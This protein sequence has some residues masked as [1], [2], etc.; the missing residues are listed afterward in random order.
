MDFD[1]SPF[2]RYGL[3]GLV[4]SWFIWRD[5]RQSSIDLKRQEA[6][7]TKIDQLVNSVNSLVRITSIE[8]MTRPNVINRARAETE[9]ILSGLTKS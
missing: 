5:Y 2:A 1:T 8:V 7:D 6:H 9:E 3:A 4:I